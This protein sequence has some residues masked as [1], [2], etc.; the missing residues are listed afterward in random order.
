[1]DTPGTW[2]VIYVNDV[3]T[4]R[5]LEVLKQ[6]QERDSHV[7]LINLSRDFGKEAA[8]TSGLD[9]ASGDAVIVIDAD[10]QDPPEVIPQLAAVWREG[11]DVVH[12][13][14]DERQGET[15]LKKTTANL[16][17]RLMRDFGHVRLPRDTGDFRLVS[18]RVVE[19]LRSLHE[20]H[21]FMKGLF[22]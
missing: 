17:Y 5:T 18:W 2:R 19:A 4:D 8:M 9:H 16:F 6:I 22:A 13:Q 15:W 12:A 3:S 14:R 7:A 11:Y 1:M 10:L 20:S 21:R